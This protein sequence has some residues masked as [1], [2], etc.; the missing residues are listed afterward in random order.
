MD[1]LSLSEAQIID[2]V[3]KEI[4][5]DLDDNER[6][7][8]EFEMDTESGKSYIAVVIEFGSRGAA[9]IDHDNKIILGE[10][11][12]QLHFTSR[13]VGMSKGTKINYIHQK[14]VFI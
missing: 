4:G 1:V 12:K 7:K 5:K 3:R 6:S 9:A 14:P 13:A 11:T 10:G 8:L 2:L